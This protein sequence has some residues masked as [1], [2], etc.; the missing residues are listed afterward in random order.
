MT[1]SSLKVV[2]KGAFREQISMNIEYKRNGQVLNF[3]RE[4]KMSYYE[5]NLIID[6]Q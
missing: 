2:F 4:Q 1:V 5:K 6:W 3:T